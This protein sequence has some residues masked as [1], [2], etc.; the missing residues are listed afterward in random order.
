MRDIS[1]QTREKEREK[2]KKKNN[3]NCRLCHIGWLA[4]IFH[5]AATHALLTELSI[6]IQLRFVAQKSSSFWLWFFREPISRSD[7]DCD[8]DCGYDYDYGY[9]RARGHR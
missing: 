2:E 8:C 9:D 4:N 7:C 3:N 1:I 5:S 6:L